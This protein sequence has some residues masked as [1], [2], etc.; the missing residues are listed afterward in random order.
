MKKEL[1]LTV[2]GQPYELY[3]KPTTLL[4]EALRDHLGLTGTKRG[5]NSSSCGACTV[6]LNGL[7]VKSCSILALQADGG[8]VLTIEGLASGAELHPLQEA[9]LDY[10]AFQCGFCTA[11]MLMSAKALL[12]E[13]P[14]PAK[15]QIKEGV[16][17]NVCRCTGYN[18]IIRAVTAVVNGEYKEK[19]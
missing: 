5:C 15:E 18:S 2:N 8:E 13:N 1:R 4:V 19:K 6:I 3:V 7:A 17:G 14:E 11:G 12:D 16:Q 10:G 9:F